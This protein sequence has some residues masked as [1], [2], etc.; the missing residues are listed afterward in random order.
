MSMS[1]LHKKSA[2]AGVLLLVLATLSLA[3]ANP[4]AKPPVEK[5]DA[6]AVQA[7]AKKHACTA[8]HAVAEQ[9]V[10]PSFQA[11]AKRYAGKSDATQTLVASLQKGATGK[12]GKQAM[13]A[14]AELTDAE[15]TA[16][17]AW[18]LATP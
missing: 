9:V 8:C 17:A 12:W 2:A 11:I 7:L 4:A 15:A 16:L 6:A 1:R 14:N 18:V 3:F 10:G 13:P 5:T